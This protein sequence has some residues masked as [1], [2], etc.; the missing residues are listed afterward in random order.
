MYGLKQILAD[1]DLRTEDVLQILVDHGYVD[2]E[3][4]EDEE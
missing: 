2:L 1:A 4:Y 3:R